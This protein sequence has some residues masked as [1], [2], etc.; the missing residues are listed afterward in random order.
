M[1][2]FIS[3]ILFDAYRRWKWEELCLWDEKSK[4]IGKGPFFRHLREMI[5]NDRGLSP[6]RSRDQHYKCLR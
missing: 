5:S 6:V 2:I 1:V 4:R 3:T